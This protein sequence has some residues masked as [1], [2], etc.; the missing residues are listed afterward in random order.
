MKPAALAWRALAAYSI[1]ILFAFLLLLVAWQDNPWKNDYFLTFSQAL[2]MASLTAVDWPAGIS[3]PL[4]LSLVTILLTQFGGLLFLS[5]ALYLYWYLTGKN[6]SKSMVS[7]A[8]F[9]SLKIS[10]IA[11]GGLFIFFLYATFLML[12]GHTMPEKLLT[13][14][15]LAVYSFNNAGFFLH[16]LGQDA[17]Q[18]EN[19][20][21]VQIGIVG[22]SLL[23]SLGIF[24]LAELFT[25]ARLRERLQHPEI[26]WSW[27][28]K[29]AVFGTIGIMGAGIALYYLFAHVELMQEKNFM[30]SVIYSGLEIIRARGF[31]FDATTLTYKGTAGIVQLIV[32]II[33]AGPLATGGGFTMLSLGLMHSVYAKNALKSM[34]IK[35]LLL[36]TRNLIK[37]IMA[38][39][40]LLA[41][42]GWI[43]LSSGITTNYL[44][45]IWSALSS[46]YLVVLDAHHGMQ[47]LACIAAFAGRWGLVVAG[48]FVIHKNKIHQHASGIISI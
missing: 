46:N 33:G 39:F 30:E 40:L 8:F 15:S 9:T 24:V 17:L 6:A 37:Y 25:P 27:I 4:P 38:V 44:E 22:G 48:L 35:V 5:I 16:F 7:K 45:I 2:G 20:F 13:A 18:V 47:I 26:D 11:E 10:C 21:L 14:F 32:S 41:V 23:G 43:F 29:I 34:D 12:E 42:L 36:L 3:I 31:G 19:H 1:L 28:T